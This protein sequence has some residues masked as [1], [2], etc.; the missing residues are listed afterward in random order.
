M[1]ARVPYHGKQ[2]RVLPWALELLAVVGNGTVRTFYG[3]M[4][5]TL[6]MPARS[7]SP[8]SPPQHFFLVCTLCYILLPAMSL[9]NLSEVATSPGQ[10]TKHHRSC[11]C[12]LMNDLDTA[13]TSYVV[14]VLE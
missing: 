13:E 14:A 6:I 5:R 4:Q 9:L 2:R 3:K 7:L 8:G 11:C 12:I 1:E 10:V